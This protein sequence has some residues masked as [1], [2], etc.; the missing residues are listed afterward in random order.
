MIASVRE[1]QKR[2]GSRAMTL[3]IIGGLVFI[4]IDQK[5]I[6]KGLILGTLF[7]VINFVL[8]GETLPLEI[9]RSQRRA[10]LVAIGSIFFR[11][12]LLAVPVVIAI[13]FSQIN[14]ISTVSGIFLVQLMI[15]ADHFFSYLTDQ[16]R[17]E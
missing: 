6:G 9:G 5:P 4:L 13:S 12:A 8:I 7:S 1:T 11:Y 16:N 10:F 2:Y 3:A 17:D 14:L 15:L